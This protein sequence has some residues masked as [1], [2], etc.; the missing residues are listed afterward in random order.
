MAMGEGGGRAKGGL[1]EEGGAKG[2][3]DIWP[4]WA[5][6][7]RMKAKHGKTEVGIALTEVQYRVTRL[8]VYGR[9]QHLGDTSLL[10]SQNDL[11]EILRKLLSIQMTM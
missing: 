9:N 6:L 5:D 3:E 10:R 11:P 8:Q 1:R 7:F 2:G 4:V